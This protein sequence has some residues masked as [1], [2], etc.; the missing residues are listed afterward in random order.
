MKSKI[1]IINCDNIEDCLKQQYPNY[2]VEKVNTK[3]NFTQI[4]NIQ[5]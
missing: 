3:I 2:K 4:I 1:K 5:K